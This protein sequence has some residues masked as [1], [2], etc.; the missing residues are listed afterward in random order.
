MLKLKSG[1]TRVLSRCFILSLALCVVSLPL[2]ASEPREVSWE[3]LQP[4]LRTLD[5]LLREA[6]PNEPLLDQ[7]PPDFRPSGDV[8]PEL[9]GQRVRLPAYVVPLDGDNE[10]LSELLLVPYFGACIHVPPPPPN[11]IVY[12]KED[13]AVDISDIDLYG[14]VW[15]TGTMITESVQTELADVGYRMEIESLEIYDPR[16][17]ARKR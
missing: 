8:V 6:D 12:V 2:K 3:D 9:N 16:A 17:E 1:V 7:P 14:P 5:K 15:A 13:D 10:S 4:P 11:Q